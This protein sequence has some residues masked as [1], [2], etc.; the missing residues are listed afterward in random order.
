MNL[1]NRQ[2]DL[3]GAVVREEVRRRTPQIIE[4]RKKAK[5]IDRSG[6]EA[7]TK[8][9]TET[10]IRGWILAGRRRER[11]HIRLCRAK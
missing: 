5:I 11:R 10:K 3:E 8:T 4:G 1:N 2:T 6:R 9:K 7:V